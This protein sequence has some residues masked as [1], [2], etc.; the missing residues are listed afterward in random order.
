MSDPST[1]A[2][3]VWENLLAIC[4]ENCKQLQEVVK[5]LEKPLPAEDLVDQQLIA[6]D[7]TEVNRKL[8][9]QLKEKCVLH[10]TTSLPKAR[11]SLQNAETTLFRVQRLSLTR[12]VSVGN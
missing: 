11:E 7:L 8:L 10:R 4:R 5:L 12:Q 2:A 6:P 9:L 3:E 1:K